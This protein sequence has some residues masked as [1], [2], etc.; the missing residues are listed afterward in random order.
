VTVPKI[1]SQFTPLR[2]ISQFTILWGITIYYRTKTLKYTKGE[3]VDKLNLKAVS[4]NYHMCVYLDNVNHVKRVLGQRESRQACTWT[5][6]IMSSVYLDNVNHV[7]RV[8]GQR[9]SCQAYTWT[10]W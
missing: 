1:L 2:M 7:K 9:E 6:W 10:M 5:T 3:K 8:L 4:I